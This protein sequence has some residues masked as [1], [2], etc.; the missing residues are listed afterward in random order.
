MKRYL[1]LL[2][3]GAV[4][5]CKNGENGQENGDKP[6]PPA[7]ISY[8]IVRTYPHDT[9]S[10]TQGLVIYKGKLYEGTGEYGHS[11]VL[12]VDLK[13]G[14]IEKQVALDKRY[15]GEGITILNDTVYQLTWQNNVVFVYTLPDFKKVKELPLQTQGW[16]I[17]TDGNQLIVSDG[18]STLYYYQPGNFSLIRKQEVTEGGSF[19]FNLNELE[20]IDGYVYANQWQAPY[21]LKID[22][23]TGKIVAKADLTEVWDRVRAREKKADVPNG[24][25]YDT[26]SKKMYVTGKFWP[27]LYEI[28]F[29][30]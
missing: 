28:Q 13:S 3:L 7:S 24:I 22:P 17:T 30:Q 21:I 11:K 19:A 27:E 14:N 16:G 4:A 20:Y 29:S 23:G 12:R 5:A 6:Q 25:A 8:S 15:F 26:A 9:A 2:L 1:P 18:S 10:F